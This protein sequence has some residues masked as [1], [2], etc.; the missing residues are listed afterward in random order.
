[1]K[2]TDDPFYRGLVGDLVFGGV[3]AQKAADHI[4]NGRGTH[5]ERQQYTFEIY[6]WACHALG[7]PRSRTQKDFNE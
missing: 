3:M 2:V 1:M 5:S 4:V 6:C 7:I